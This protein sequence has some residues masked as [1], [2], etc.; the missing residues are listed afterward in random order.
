MVR[1]CSQLVYRQIEPQAVPATSPDTIIALHGDEGGLEDLVPCASSL[2]SGFRIYAPEAARGV[3]LGTTVTSRTWFGGTLS[4]PE[5]ASFGDSLAQLERFIHDVRTRH[6]G[7][8]QIRP[9]LLGY[10]QGAVLALSVAAIAPDLISG[11][12]AVCGGLPTFSNPDLMEFVASELPILLIGDAAER[13]AH[14]KMI[15]AT[16]ARL[17]KLGKHLTVRWVQ[18]AA[19]LGAPVS[20][21]LRA[22]LLDRRSRGDGRGHGMPPDQPRATTSPVAPGRRYG[23]RVNSNI[24]WYR[25][26][27]VGSSGPEA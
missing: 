3:Y 23:A 25:A 19:K 18:R 27:R 21:E 16:A 10:D 13:A 26:T 1:T 2:G 6:N 7:D 11:V 20:D 14:T 24:V 4:Q 17:E 15:D 22:W 9:W 8:G 12:M 5:P